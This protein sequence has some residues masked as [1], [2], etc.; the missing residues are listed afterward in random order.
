MG[1][2]NVTADDPTLAAVLE[3]KGVVD[4]LSVAAEPPPAGRIDWI[5]ARG[6]ECIAAG[7]EDHGE[8]DHPLIWAELK[9][10]ENGN[11]L[12]VK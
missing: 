11:S 6:L 10:P 5:L 1:D 4:A 8:S 3:T 12:V 7:A 9:P 2:L